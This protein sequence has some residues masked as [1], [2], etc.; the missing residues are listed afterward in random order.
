MNTPHF[1]SDFYTSWYEDAR[2][3]N[4]AEAEAHWRE[5]GGA[6]ERHP[7]FESLAESKN[8]DPADVP[9]TFDWEQYRDLNTD[10]PQTWGRW[11]ITLHLLTHGLDEDRPY[12]APATGISSGTGVDEIV[13]LDAEW[14]AEVHRLS[15]PDEAR[16]HYSR[17]GRQNLLA[18]NQNFSPIDY[19]KRF[20]DV[21]A[22]RIHPVKHYRQFGHLEGRE[23]TS[24][25][26]ATERGR[27]LHSRAALHAARQFFDF[28]AAHYRN[29]RPDLTKAGDDFDFALH[30]QLNGEREDTPP[31]RFFDPGYYRERYA[32][33]LQGW[34]GTALAHFLSIGILLG[35]LPSREV[36]AGMQRARLASAVAWVGHWTEQDWIDV[37]TPAEVLE[38]EVDLET[39]EVLSSVRVGRRRINW[40]VP[41]FS[42]GGG[43]HTTMFRAARTLARLGWE[44]VFWIP[45]E[46]TVS[47]IDDLYAEFIGHFPISPISFRR[48]EDG[49]HEVAGEVLVAS[50]WDT[51]YLTTENK[52]ANA[53]LYFVQ[54]RESLFLPAGADALR[55]EWTYRLGLDFVCAGP[56]LEQLVEPYGGLHTSF[57]LCAEPMFSQR[58][59]PLAERD[60]LAAVYVRGHSARR[61]S[62]MMA[63]AANKL[64][65]L[66]LGEVVVFGDDHPAYPLGDK[67]VNA[68]VIAPAEMA[69]LFQKSRFG[70]VASATNYSIMPVELA[71]AGTVVVQPASESTRETTDA[72]GAHSV[73]P[74]A[75]GIVRFVAEQA[76]R[77][78]QESFDELR[79]AYHSF[80]RS[81]SW[82]GEFEK[83]GA[84]MEENFL[85]A[86]EQR[87]PA[88]RRRSVGV[89]IPTYY[90][91][92]EFTEVIEAVHGQLTSF[93]VELQI[94]DS[95]L[96]G[97][98]APVV[99]EV[100][101]RG[102]AKVHP[103]DARTFSHGP[104]RTEAA[105][106]LE[107]DY[108]AYITQDAI[109]AH[110]YWLE[111]LI[112]P[113]AMLPSCGYSFG[114]HRAYSEHHELY[115][116]ELKQHFN[117]LR[118]LGYVMER[119]DVAERFDKDPYFVATVCFN[120]D[121]N[122]GY[123]GDLLREHGF[124]PVPFAEDQAIARKLLTM[125]YSR[126]YAPSSQVIHSHDYTQDPELAYKRGTEEAAA[127]YQNFGL[128]RFRNAKEVVHAKKHEAEQATDAAARSG[129]RES[130]LA[131]FLA[132]KERYIDGAWDASKRYMDEASGRPKLV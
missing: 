92:E 35:H 93:D 73:E 22:K 29:R 85:V 47:Q 82:E 4:A 9:P 104:A 28:D 15:G 106:L 50:S 112:A 41:A 84:W 90:P 64:A 80:A 121:N 97:E 127:L 103:I 81:L 105:R 132:S 2:G 117:G 131:A 62:E 59:L 21:A 78:T 124:P 52:N 20:G 76:R 36:A 77:L 122:A 91:G 69:E 83:I 44:S 17:V 126:A 16:N 66:G 111:S 25:T 75:E 79:G 94:I 43:G 99:A 14:Y 45:G 74:S 130:E 7:T 100:E 88:P 6:A 116:V 65:E 125:G 30:Y 87:E 51:A 12:T 101:R 8:V 3:L 27:T 70:L 11:L 72:R 110:E 67:V 56:W 1:D 68:G 114:S 63:D 113:I 48:F 96:D 10:I 42:K 98:V 24:P 55:A 119:K 31:S 38:S 109:P 115:D 71:A 32:T 19:W 57:E 46:K 128:L 120:S 26:A 34:D 123:R 13:E 58:D 53:R 18:P 61:A 89:V 60:V 49:F 102:L 37:Q 129:L 5:K 118:G 39:T 23:I 107:T 40:V 95:R 86:E 54:D 108:Y 33:E